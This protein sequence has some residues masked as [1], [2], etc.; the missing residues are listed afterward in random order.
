MCRHQSKVVTHAPS[1]SFFFREQDAVLP[2]VHGFWWYIYQTE[3]YVH[4]VI[5]RW[6]PVRMLDL[7]VWDVKR[8]VESLAE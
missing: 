7:G 6:P 3:C 2:G 4:C 5:L 8:G 1:S